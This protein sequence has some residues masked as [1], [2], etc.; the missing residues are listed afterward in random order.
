MS[1]RE[2]FYRAILVVGSTAL[3]L[4]ACEA[5]V[6]LYLRLSDPA[7]EDLEARLEDSRRASPER[8]FSRGNLMGLVRASADPEIVYELK[9]GLRGRFAGQ[10][11]EISSQGLRDREYP[12]QKP[13]GTLRIAGLG[14]S[15]MFGWGVG[16]PELY[17]EVL[18]RR[19]NGAP[20]TPRVEVLNFAV[21]GYNTAMEVAV[22]ERKALAFDP[23]LVILHFVPNDLALPPFLQPPRRLGS[24]G[25]SF[26]LELVRNRLQ[27]LPGLR[28]PRLFPRDAESPSDPRQV[29][30]RYRHMVGE[31]G[32]RRAMA[33]L[34]TLTRERSLPVIVITLQQAEEPWTLVRQVVEEH[35]FH[36]LVTGPTFLSYLAEH[37]IEPSRQG[38]GET[39]WVSPRDSHPNALGHRLYAEMLFETLQDLGITEGSVSAPSPT[40]G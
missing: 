13:P 2:L 1:A 40:L 26:L 37:G 33:R 4:A 10:P 38:W 22:F 6:R 3:V 15:V 32:F 16:Q 23:D 31:D 17:L 28:E 39:L 24:L 19:L 12:R 18:E 27:G 25:R 35:G 20:R 11:F 34:A 7:A 5:G 9:P 30:E 36:L 21:P 29:P 8:V 14:D